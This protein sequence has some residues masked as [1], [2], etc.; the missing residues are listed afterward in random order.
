MLLLWRPI[1]CGL[2][3]RL[4]VVCVAVLRLCSMRR[5]VIPMLSMQV[6]SHKRM[7]LSQVM[8]EMRAGDH[9]QDRQR[10]HRCQRHKTTPGLRG[11]QAIHDTRSGCHTP[12]SP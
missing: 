12:R 10:Q 6:G 11:L 1:T 9:D 7:L 4:S 3:M 5:V 8:H 2:W